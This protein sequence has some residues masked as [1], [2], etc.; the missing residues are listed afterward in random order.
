MTCRH[1]LK[2]YV[3]G[4]FHLILDYKKISHI[5]YHRKVFKS[6]VVVAFFFKTD[7]NPNSK[8]G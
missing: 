7:S 5:Y 3:K 2:S 6:N 8:H 1:L 4:I